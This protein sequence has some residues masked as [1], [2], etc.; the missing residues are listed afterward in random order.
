MNFILTCNKNFG[1]GVKYFGSNLGLNIGS[2]FG[3]NMGDAVL[4]SDRIKKV[5]R[6]SLN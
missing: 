3:S 5:E 1:K 2:N 4:L 6:F